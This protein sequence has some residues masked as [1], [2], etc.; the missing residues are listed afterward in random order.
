[1]A[2]YTCDSCGMSVNATCGTCD[3]PLVN[4]TLT[5]DLTV[6]VTVRVHH[7]LIVLLIVR[8]IQNFQGIFVGVNEAGIQ[9]IGQFHLVVDE[10]YEKEDFAPCALIYISTVWQILELF[11]ICHK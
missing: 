9:K 4:E 1:M 11:V 6:N 7:F 3:A 10:I 2:T 5:K 8:I